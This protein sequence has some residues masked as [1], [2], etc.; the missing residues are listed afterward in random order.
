MSERIDTTRYACV[1]DLTH[2]FRKTDLLSGLTAIEQETL[3]RNIGVVDYTGEGGQIVPK[4]VTY[5][6]LLGY[7]TNNTLVTGA[8]YIMTDFKTIYQSKVLNSSGKYIT[9]GNTV[10]VS[11]T[12]RLIVT[13]LS[14]NRLDPR[15]LIDDVSTINWVVTYNITKETLDDG[16]TTRGKITYLK[17]DKG[18]SAYY[19]FKNIKFHRS[20]GDFFTF[21]DIVNGVIT[22]STTLYN[23]KYNTIEDG[24]TDNVFMGDTYNNIIKSG[25][26]GNTFLNGCHDTVLGWSSTNNTFN[27]SVCYMSG[28]LYNQVIL[29]GDTTLSTTISKTIHKVN[30][31]TIV[32]FLDPIT[33]A[34]QIIKL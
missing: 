32:S 2:Y 31:A 9:W 29:T 4:E 27:E 30:E 8:R 33:Y 5:E 13:A 6:T 7:V 1:A 14:T 10:N 11:P 21:S 12:M 20:N 17:D 18:N 3:R 25:C 16:N 19:D 26:S 34:Y 15:V 24:C 28:S 23:T 22:D